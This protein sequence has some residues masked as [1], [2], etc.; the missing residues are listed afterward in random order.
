MHRVY[1]DP[2]STNRS[3]IAYSGDLRY[4]DGVPLRSTA[5]FDCWRVINGRALSIRNHIQDLE[6]QFTDGKD[7]EAQKHFEEWKQYGAFLT[8]TDLTHILKTSRKVVDRMLKTGQLPAAKLGGQYRVRTSDFQRW[9]D[10]EVQRE[11]KNLLHTRS[12]RD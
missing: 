10:G 6:R 1:T 9:W 3:G 4:I 11:Q 2:D 7:L 12:F 8:V 5:D